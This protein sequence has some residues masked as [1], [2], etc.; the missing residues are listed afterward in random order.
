VI[1]GAP[2]GVVRV[3]PA[4]W[5]A[6]ARSLRE[7]GARFATLY[8]G[9]DG[10]LR[11]VTISPEGVP[12]IVRSSV[13]RGA[14]SVV[15][16][17]PTAAWS[18][19]E[20]HD[21]YGVTFAGHEPLRPLLE[22]A[23][24]WRTPVTGEG[25]HEIAVGPIHAGVIESGHFRIHAVG[26]LML[27]VD[28]RLFYKH[29][30]LE[31]A[32]EGSRLGHGIRF[33]MRACAGC[34][35]ANSLAYALAA[36]QIIGVEADQE[37][38]RVR[39]LLLELERLWNHLNDLSALCAGI[40]FAPGA[41]AFAALKEEAQR[42]NQRLFGH[43]F[44]FRTIAVTDTT[45]YPPAR[46]ELDTEQV[47]DV[48]ATLT[49]IARRL[50]VVWRAI[51][52]NASVQERLTGAGVLTRKAALRCG[53]VGPAARASGLDLDARVTGSLRYG[54]FSPARLDNPTGDVHARANIRYLELLATLELLFALAETS[55]GPL[56]LWTP[57]GSIRP[58]RR[59]AVG[60][61][62][63]IGVGV[64]ES[65]RGETVCCVEATNGVIDRLSLRT[66]SH[67]NWPSVAEAAAGNLVGEFPLVNK[68]FELCYAC[69]D[70]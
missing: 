5:R 63:G 50:D 28:V 55:D 48:R 56:P 26:E 30:G 39:M 33:A 42:L 14:E 32:A 41:M 47:S 9:L 34:A 22:H 40:G 37:T 59:V 66:S 18:E 44:L 3:Q 20:A 13:G 31:Q 7:S 36:E 21:V 16:V 65:A 24:A 51:V 11:L 8:A 45:T 12:S 60:D 29:R 69:V 58:G 38:T 19:R 61:G 27:L 54:G 23:G 2:V 67:A 25:V 4:A 17:F 10:D 52:F 43:R 68:S 49:R 6:Q 53:T 1:D 35:V 70:R 15:G 64:V 46:R 57:K 62:T